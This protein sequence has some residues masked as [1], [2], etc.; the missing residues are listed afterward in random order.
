[1]VDGVVCERCVWIALLLLVEASSHSLLFPYVPL[2]DLP[3]PTLNLSVSVCASVCVCVCF[4]PIHADGFWMNEGS[5]DERSA[6]T[7]LAVAKRE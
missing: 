7:A 2:F 1:M 6:A 4:V 5:H 3:F